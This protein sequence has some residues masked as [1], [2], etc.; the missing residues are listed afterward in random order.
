MLNLSQET[1]FLKN[2]NFQRFTVAEA[3][4]FE[5]QN[6][7]KINKLSKEIIALWA[8]YLPENIL[9][10]TVKAK[11][12]KNPKFFG[13]KLCEKYSVDYPLEKLTKDEETETQ[14]LSNS[15]FTISYTSLEN[16][17]TASFLK[18]LV[19]YISQ[20]T[21]YVRSVF[22]ITHTTSKNVDKT[23]LSLPALSL[24]PKN[25]TSESNIHSG[26]F[27]PIL[28]SNSTPSKV[29]TELF[30]NYTTCIF[31]LT[32]PNSSVET[33]INIR[34][35]NTPLITEQNFSMDQK[36]RSSYEQASD[37]Q[38]VKINANTRSNK[39]SKKIKPF[40]ID[41]FGFK[42][43][44]NFVK[45]R[46]A[47]DANAEAAQ[48]AE[49][50]RT[51]EGTYQSAHSNNLT[52]PGIILTEDSPIE[53][54]FIDEQ[55]ILLEARY[56][57]LKKLIF[58]DFKNTHPSEMSD[59][60]KQ[61]IETRLNEWFTKEKR[62]LQYPIMKIHTNDLYNQ[63]KLLEAQHKTLFSQ[64]FNN[65]TLDLHNPLK[66]KTPRGGFTYN[67]LFLMLIIDWYEFEKKYLE[68]AQNRAY[69]LVRLKMLKH[70][71]VFKF[72]P[73]SSEFIHED[74]RESDTSST[75]SPRRS[76]DIP[77]P[78][79]STHLKVSSSKDVSNYDI[80]LEALVSPS[81]S[82]Y[83]AHI[84]VGSKVESDSP[85]DTDRG[86]AL[87]RDISRLTA[88]KLPD[89]AIT[90][91]LD[92][93]YDDPYSHY[94]Y[95]PYNHYPIQDDVDEESETTPIFLIITPPSVER[96]EITPDS[97]NRLITSDV[98]RSSDF[99]LYPSTSRP[100]ETIK[101]EGEHTPRTLH[102]PAGHG[103]TRIS[104][105][106]YFA[107]ARSDQ[108]RTRPG[109]APHE[110]AQIMFFSHTWSR[111]PANLSVQLTSIK[112]RGESPITPVRGTW[113]R[114]SDSESHA[115]DTAPLDRIKGSSLLKSFSSE[116]SNSRTRVFPRSAFQVKGTESDDA[117]G[118]TTTESFPE[119]YS[120]QVT[121]ASKSLVDVPLS[122]AEG[123]SVLRSIGSN[124]ANKPR[125]FL[126]ITPEAGPEKVV[127][128]DSDSLTP[129][130]SSPIIA[131]SFSQHEDSYTSQS[132]CIDDKAIE[133]YTSS[134]SS[135]SGEDSPLI[136]APPHR[137]ANV[138][139]NPVPLL[140][141]GDSSNNQLPQIL[142]PLVQT[143][144]IPQ[145]ANGASDSNSNI[146][147][148]SGLDI[149]YLIGNLKTITTALEL[150][151]PESYIVNK[152]ANLYR[153]TWVK[154]GLF[155]TATVHQIYKNDLPVLHGLPFIV[156]FSAQEL[157]N[158]LRVSI[159][160]GYSYV[161]NIF[162]NTAIGAFIG[163]VKTGGAEMQLSSSIRGGALGALIS[164]G[165][166]ALKCYIDYNHYL[167]NQEEQG[168]IKGLNAALSI[169]TM[170]LVPLDPFSK[171]VAAATMVIIS[172]TLLTFTTETAHLLFD[173]HPTSEPALIG[174]VPEV[175]LEDS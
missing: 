140:N 86:D 97:S 21:H 73:R 18:S 76:F 72:K 70:S 117:H 55:K 173:N 106:R 41:D 154:I 51:E 104:K 7:Y 6:I 129:T 152:I 83:G 64:L 155:S 116:Q 1:E 143:L 113:E 40:F 162:V 100:R 90:A 39:R 31:N 151:L 44:E 125:A 138:F 102:T 59:D 139:H 43:Y 135:E 137:S 78:T 168:F 17:I 99:S 19:S 144:S 126:L 159:F 16:A 46:K 111:P 172:D 61:F 153:S 56:M 119:L 26:V 95:Y 23:D 49:Q 85:R 94:G 88:L 93:Y 147:G 91:P 35:V 82:P 75:P 103:N 109:E 71:S 149:L 60:I 57:V 50:S 164:G 115:L 175:K 14:S 161:T 133:L 171:V 141:F 22:S 150:S 166:S 29:T 27:Y 15:T 120:D 36:N 77:V 24:T 167:I 53:S 32:K 63:K 169:A 48:P 96:E 163:A 110:S 2:I 142:P 146:E 52:D 12:S 38:P 165:S 107:I 69:Y 118:K 124:G 28:Q 67:N 37:F 10:Y 65:L 136:A 132:E 68:D 33:I 30:S 81:T 160:T 34:P 92:L 9:Y 148:N 13:Q 20:V 157:L 58:E 105:L 3:M 131:Q 45:M 112:R 79:N 170:I 89:T 11:I 84:I 156:S 114:S 145:A 127:K 158:S 80:A 54:T 101:S 87:D 25:S 8:E 134:S 174:D 128:Y 5:A 108:D 62:N 130:T 122:H 98:I 4:V 121:V 123:S 42:T 47:K 66:I 74:S